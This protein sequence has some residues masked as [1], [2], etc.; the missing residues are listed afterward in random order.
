M[1]KSKGSSMKGIISVLL[2]L[3]LAPC[4]FAL[5][6]KA[7][8]EIAL[9]GNPAVIAAQKKKEAADARLAQA[10]GAFFP[11]IK[12]DGS[13]G[14][15]YNQPAA[16][17]MT[18]QTTL[19]A[20]TQ[21]LTF[22][23]DAAVDSRGYTA[24]FSQPLFV[25]ALFPGY[26]IAQRSADLTKEDLRKTVLEVS[27]NVTQAYFGVLKAARMVDL[28]KESKAMA[29]SHYSQVKSMLNAGVATRA[30]LLRAE[31]Q[32]ANSE[33][34]LTRAGNGLEI[35]KDAFN[36]A[37]GRELENEVRLEEEGFSSAAV[38]LPDY[39]QILGQAYSNRPEWKQFIY[40]K[41]IGEENLRVAQLAYLPTVML[42]GS[43]GNR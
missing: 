20:V 39:Q 5:D 41:E 36:N 38:K 23:I 19:G 9:M 13:Y 43:S 7:S 15:S 18:T 17:Q 26:K 12:L 25:G 3:F 24:S 32:Q 1:I 40:S 27:F 30:D 14:R 11:T 6:L 35:A 10:V 37:L 16:T 22:G 2:L 8:I 29:D 42:T 21:T 31:V 28:A 4:S 34:T 33:V